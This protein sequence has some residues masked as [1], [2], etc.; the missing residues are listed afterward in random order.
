MERQMRQG[1]ACY[2][3]QFLSDSP[4]V[5]RDTGDG[6]GH[7]RPRLE[8]G[9]NRR[10]VALILWRGGFKFA[11]IR[12]SSRITT[13]RPIAYDMKL[14]KITIIVLFAALVVL[15]CY[16]GYQLRA[17]R[18]YWKRE[19]RFNIALHIG[20]Y[21]AAE[22]GAYQKEGRDIRSDYGQMILED[23]VVYEQQFG[24]DVGTNLFA[25]HFDDAK[26]IARQVAAHLVPISSMLTNLP[27]APDAKIIFE[28]QKD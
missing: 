20:L 21:H 22:R 1:R 16:L 23:V 2:V 4:D 13:V 6:S 25:K 17:Q 18:E 7:Q 5:A 24:E 12:T 8:L 27:F 15:C 14:K 11:D 28:K 26:V 19:E 10:F 3:L 9:R